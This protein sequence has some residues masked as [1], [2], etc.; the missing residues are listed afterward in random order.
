M[1]GG[2]SRRGG[3]RSP[4]TR[5]GRE[6]ARIQPQEINEGGVELRAGADEDPASGVVVAGGAATPVIV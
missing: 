5:S 3:P 6:R 4:D 2:E 1:D